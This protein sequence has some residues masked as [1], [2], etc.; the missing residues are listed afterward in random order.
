MNP[1]LEFLLSTVYDGNVAPAHR[2]D[3]WK[4]TLTD[5]TI[6]AQFIR[7]V[8]PRLISQLLGFDPP[9]VVSALLFPFRSPH[10]GF[11]DHVRVTVFPSLTDAEG[12]AVKYLQPRRSGVRLY[13]VARCLE[14][15]LRSDEPL[16]ITEGEKKACC[17]AQLGYPVVGITGV[18]GWHAKGSCLL[19]PDFD[20]ILLRGR[21]VE[22]LPDSD[23]QTNPN[24]ERAIRSLGYALAARGAQP[25]APGRKIPISSKP[26][27]P[28]AE[29]GCLRHGLLKPGCTC[30]TGT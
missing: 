22:L 12:H 4:S 18:Q 16:W 29:S 20:A 15:V 1:H 24:V 21:V 30:R 28:R 6:A 14:R 25:G 27:A 3:L 23:Y 26:A 7:S 17:V 8:P 11:M 10:G 9:G 13:F 5:E 2:K 19:L